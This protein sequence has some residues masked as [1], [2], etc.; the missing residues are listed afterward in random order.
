MRHFTTLSKLIGEIIYFIQ[1][2]N[3]NTQLISQQSILLEVSSQKRSF[4]EIKVSAIGNLSKKSCEKKFQH[5]CVD[6]IWIYRKTMKTSTT[7]FTISPS[8]ITICDAKGKQKWI[9]F[10]LFCFQFEIS[11]VGFDKNV[12]DE[13]VLLSKFYKLRH[14]LINI[15]SYFQCFWE[16]I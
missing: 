14:K 5:F 12:H 6:F 8:F 11:N 3:Q 9:W 2:N 10:V 7:V 1:E 4:S 15:A 16:N 13:F